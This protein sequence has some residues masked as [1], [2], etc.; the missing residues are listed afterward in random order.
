MLGWSALLRRALRVLIGMGIREVVR[1]GRRAARRRDETSSGEP[2]SGERPTIIDVERVDDD[3]P[4]ERFSE[5]TRRV[6]AR[7]AELH[8]GG[9]VT[10]EGLLLALIDT[11]LPSAERL[12]RAGTDLEVLRRHLRAAVETA[13]DRRPTPEARRALRQAPVLADRRGGGTVEPR[14][15][16]GALLAR[17][18]RLIGTVDRY[19]VGALHRGFEDR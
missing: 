16:L 3:R 9:G 7:A 1:H 17:D 11:H 6:V 18:G 12:V 13:G 19:T 2:T 15:L 8:G 5:T 4:F 10:G 14:D